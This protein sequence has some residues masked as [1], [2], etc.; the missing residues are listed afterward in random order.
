MDSSPKIRTS[1]PHAS[2]QDS[3]QSFIKIRMRYWIAIITLIL[4]SIFNIGGAERDTT[5]LPE[6]LVVSKH[7]KL[8]HMLAYV[9]EYSTMTTYTDTVF[10]FREKMVDFMLPAEKASFKGWTNPRVLTSRSYYRFSNNQGL[11]SVS[12][13]CQHHFSWSDWI[14]I[15]PYLRVPE[16]LVGIEMGVDTIWGKYSP[17]E[18]WTKRKDSISIDIDV[19]ADIAGGKWVKNLSGFF[20]KGLEFN[21]I[22]IGFDFE[23]VI[24]YDM[25]ALDLTRYSVD[26]ESTGRGY[27]M[28]MFNRKDE[29]FFVQTTAEVYILDREFI[30]LKEA[31]KWERCSFDINEIGIYEPSGTPPLS[32]DILSLIWRV[33]NIDKNEVK[34]DFVPDQNMISNKLGGRNFKVGRRALLMLKEATGISKYRARRNLKRQWNEFRKERNEYNEGRVL[35]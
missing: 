10:L 32:S 20:K 9:R 18:I 12:D 14:G 16:R 35:R 33:E 3:K 1:T 11:D 17:F 23:N 30:T 6:V 19:L 34:L 24:G 7:H 2:G 22:R 8:L 4:T 28:F 21:R 13:V 26:M 15:V 5:V 31:K 25:S 29:S 27:E